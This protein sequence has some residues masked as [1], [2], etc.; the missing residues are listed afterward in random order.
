[1]TIIC[2]LDPSLTNT[3]VAVLIDGLPEVITSTG[4]GTLDSDTY[5]ARSRRVRAVAAKVLRYIPDTT[6][7]A[8]IEGPSYGSSGGAAFDRAALWH[9]LFAAL[10]AKNI[11]IA[12]VAP[13]TR[14][15]WATGSGAADKAAVTAA[16]REWWPNHREHIVNSDRADALV[17]A[18]IGAYHLR[19]PLPF[20]AKKRHETGLKSVRWPTA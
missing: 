1:M 18:A 9:G 10:D 7:L 6:T 3:G 20:E 8:V 4:I 14:A 15:T 5:Q 11:P 19:Q 17:L 16:V 13:R 12:V 2:G